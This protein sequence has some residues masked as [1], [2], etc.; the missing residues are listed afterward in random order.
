M[1][2]IGTIIHCPACKAELRHEMV[3]VS[4]LNDAQR[5]IDKLAAY[6]REVAAVVFG[7]EALARFNGGP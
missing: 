2:H 5:K 6:I 4:Y 7:R 1:R 3:H